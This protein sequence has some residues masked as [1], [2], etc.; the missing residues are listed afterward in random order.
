MADSAFV[1]ADI[2][3]LVQFEKKS[4][5]AIKEFDAIKEKFNDIN[6][7]LL[8]K[9]KGEGKDAYKKESDHIMENIGGIRIFLIPSTMEWSKTLRTLIFSLTKNSESLIRIH[10]RMKENKI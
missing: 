4:D 6:T 5:E 1:L 8:K 10:R 2:D 7:T 3:K 9:W